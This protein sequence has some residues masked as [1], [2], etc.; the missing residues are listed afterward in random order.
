M[1][2]IAL[3]LLAFMVGDCV[4][5]TS[6]IFKGQY[7]TVLSVNTDGTYDLKDREWTLPHVRASYLAPAAWG[8]CKGN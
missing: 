7:W 3:L 4:Q 1:K 5:I 8:E 2:R 6:G